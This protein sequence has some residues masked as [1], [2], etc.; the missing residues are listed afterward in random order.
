ME[1]PFTRNLLTLRMA[2]TLANDGLAFRFSPRPT[3]VPKSTQKLYERSGA[4]L[5]SGATNNIGSYVGESSK[6]T[7]GCMPPNSLPTL[8]PKSTQ[9]M[10][11]RMYEAK[12]GWL[13]STLK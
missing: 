12:G 11:A 1:G 7:A 2:R 5:V 9:T 8:K 3:I 6:T 4:W 13:A 10:S